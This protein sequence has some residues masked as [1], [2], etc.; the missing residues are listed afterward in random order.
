MLGIDRPY[1]C[2]HETKHVKKWIKKEA[3]TQTRKQ[4]STIEYMEV[5]VHRSNRTRQILPNYNPNI[6]NH[7]EQKRD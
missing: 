3:G 1:K 2:I 7:V 6:Y 5:E 4:K